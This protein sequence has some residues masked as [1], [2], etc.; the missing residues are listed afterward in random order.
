LKV[1]DVMTCNLYSLKPDDT[2]KFTAGY[3]LSHHIDGAPVLDAD[4]VL[5]GL[6]TKS[7]I[8]RAVAEQIDFNTPISELM[9]KNIETVKPEDDILDLLEINRGR[10]PVLGEQEVLGIVTRTDL[11]WGY[12]KYVMEIS[13]QLEAI[14][15][16]VYNPIIVIDINGVITMCNDAFEKTFAINKKDIIG[17]YIRECLPE[18]RLDEII[19]SGKAEPLARVNIKGKTYMSNRTP[20]YLKDEIVGAVAVMQDISELEEISRELN[21]SK[22]ISEELNAIIESSFDGIFVTDAAGRVLKVNQAYERISGIKVSQVLGKTMKELVQTG[23]YDR[24]VTLEVIESH[25]PVTI[26]QEVVTGKT[27]LVTGNPLFDEQG[28][29][30][31]VVTNVRDITELNQLQRDLETMEGLKSQYEQELNKLREELKG[32]QDL[33][34]RSE[35]MKNLINLVKRLSGVDSTVLIQGESGVGKELIAASLHKNSKRAD[36]PY[37]KINCGA[38]AE[39]LLESELFGYEG[40]AFTGAKKEGKAGLFEIA[41]GGT[42]FLDEIAEVSPALQVKLLRVLQERVLTRVGGVKQIDIDVRIIAATN[43]DLENMVRHGNFR[44]DLF[45]RLNVVP[46]SIP[47]LRERKDDIPALICYFMEKFN[48]RYEMKR[49]LD[50]AVIKVLYDYDWPGNVRELQNVI[51]RLVV[52]SN[53]RIIGREDILAYLYPAVNPRETGLRKI[54]TLKFAVEELEEQLLREAIQQYRTTRKVAEVLDINQSTVVRKAARYG[55]KINK[56]E[57]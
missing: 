8:M 55:I 21:Y 53:H 15:S 34:Y 3:F 54:K 11:M 25:S 52:M 30:F 24:S 14:I 51:E 35:K 5:Q 22:I 1:K 57:S 47:P 23:I 20:V 31:R 32:S 48:R 27:I 56:E 6:F 46:L 13:N 2:I 43:Q 28:Q 33:I 38:I 17:L 37:I 49:E 41:N 44:K 26:V 50:Y 4:G 16:S 10:L 42:L 12:S 7:H 29:L 45:Y 39:N 36:K 18:S 19:C 9:T 40:G